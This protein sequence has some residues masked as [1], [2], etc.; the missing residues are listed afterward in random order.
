MQ[1]CEPYLQIVEIQRWV[2]RDSVVV[3]FVLETGDKFVIL[4]PFN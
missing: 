1:L 3:I 4:T 2:C